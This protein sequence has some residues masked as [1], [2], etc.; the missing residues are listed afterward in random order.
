MKKTHP[1]IED[2]IQR[3]L[4][5]AKFSLPFFGELNLGVNYRPKK[6]DNITMSIYVKA[7][8]IYCNYNGEFLDNLNTVKG[9]LRGD[10]EEEYLYNKWERQKQVNFL[11]IHNNFHLLFDHPKRGISGQFDEK[12]ASVAQDMIINSTI[13]EDINAAF[14]SIPK[15]VDTKENKQKGIVGRNMALTLPAKFMKGDKGKPIFEELYNWLKEE[16]RK[17]YI[18][19]RNNSCPVCNGDG[20]VNGSTCNE[21]DGSGHD[22][23]RSNDYGDFG[24][25][26]EKNSGKLNSV[27]CFSLDSIFELIE[28]GHDFLD[29]SVGDEV[30][31][32][33]RNMFVNDIIDNLRTRGLVP[34][35]MEETLKKLRKKRKDH[36]R[37]IKRSIS[38]D[39]IGHLKHKTIS[40]PN[41]RGIEGLKGYK[42]YSTKIN[43][44]MDT[45][46]SM[47]GMFEK[48]LEYVFQK[49]IVINMCQVDTEVH[50]IETI[51]SMR[52]MQRM[53]IKGMGGTVLQ[54]AIDLITSSKEY[55]KFNTVILTDGYCDTLD[56][57]RLNGRVLAITCGTDIPLSS[58]AK[59][60]YKQIVIED[61]S[62]KQ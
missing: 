52:D 14:V 59:K 13:L 16:Q 53:D 47:Y 50:S 42:K 44:I 56:L 58:S 23:D 22:R 27:K 61:T 40:R 60:G 9:E 31:Q 49:D 51:S 55:N 43:V 26:T 48:V 21:C 3:M 25:Y 57:S 62:N 30:S 38:K 45:S 15:Y 36:L 34:G 6:G 20:E 7:A 4:V 18:R 28:K 8:G 5:D 54:P 10:S 29:N 2:C 41:R 37:E 11:I 1:L 46:G 33:M 24:V 12:L 17:F 39:I 19:K 35:E 32:E